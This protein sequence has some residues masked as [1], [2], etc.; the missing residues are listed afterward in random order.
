[1]TSPYPPP[2]GRGVY[3]RARRA[4]WGDG[5]KDDL[6]PVPSPPEGKGDGIAVDG[7]KAN[8][9]AWSRCGARVKL[10]PNS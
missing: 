8:E 5:G 10:A 9:Q 3:K 4:G 1:M 6:I 7:V 2:K